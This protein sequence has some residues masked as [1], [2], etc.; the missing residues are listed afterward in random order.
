MFHCQY[1]ILFYI[2]ARCRVTSTYLLIS[3][4]CV[5]VLCPAPPTPV[6]LPRPLTTAATVKA[7]ASNLSFLSTSTSV[8]GRQHFSTRFIAYFFHVIIIIIIIIIIMP[9][10]ST[11]VYLLMT[12]P[13][14]FSYLFSYFSSNFLKTP[15]D[16]MYRG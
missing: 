9:Y 16:H 11:T 1:V 15:R 6:V 3:L 2:T 4:A 8:V 14:D 13:I 7:A 12:A 10:C 5:L